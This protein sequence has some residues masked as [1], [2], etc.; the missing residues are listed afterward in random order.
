[1]FDKIQHIG[2][3][4]ADLDAAI[5]WFGKG[6]GAQRA[7]GGPI[8]AAPAIGLASGG[9]NAF[10]RFGQVE[11]ELLEPTHRSG[12]ASRGD[13]LLSGRSGDVASAGP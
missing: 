4:V 3:L 5:A 9:R 6:F 12:L 1:M 2:Y 10:V 8:A 7:G 13:P 11:V